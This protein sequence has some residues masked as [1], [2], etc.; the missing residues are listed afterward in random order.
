MTKNKTFY[1]NTNKGTTP[2]KI[3]KKKFRFNTANKSLVPKYP[4]N[5]MCFRICN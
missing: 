2:G 3:Q 4:K 1:P 5:E